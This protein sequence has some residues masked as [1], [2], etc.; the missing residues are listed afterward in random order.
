MVITIFF[1]KIEQ[2]LFK[3]EKINLIIGFAINKNR[4]IISYPF[5]N[6]SSKILCMVGKALLQNPSSSRFETSLAGNKTHSHIGQMAK[7]CSS[8]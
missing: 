5:V 2:I 1:S 8:G 3:I 7:K 4:K 6:C